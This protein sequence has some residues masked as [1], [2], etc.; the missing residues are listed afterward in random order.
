MYSY[1]LPQ[2]LIMPAPNGREVYR[3]VARKNP[4]NARRICFMT[5]LSGDTE[6]LDWVRAEGLAF[7]RKPF[8]PKAT[9]SALLGQ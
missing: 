1:Q 2:R 4:D 8:D 6:L 3:N 5:G 9:V 7:V